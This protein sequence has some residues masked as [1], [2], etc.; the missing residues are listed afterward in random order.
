M[1]HRPGEGVGLSLNVYFR[2]YSSIGFITEFLEENFCSAKK[3]DE[4]R[5]IPLHLLLR[6]GN[7]F[8]K[9]DMKTLL[10]CLALAVSRKDM[11]GDL[12]LALE[13]KNKCK[14]TVI[15]ILLIHYPEA[16]KAL[17]VDVHHILYL[18]FNQGAEDRTILGLLNKAT[19]IST[20]VEKP[21]SLLPIHL[22]TQNEQSPFIVHNL[23]RRYMPIDIK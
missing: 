5:D 11:N 14:N 21:S 9:V 1:L 8:D 19:K 12:P 7:K 3:T 20:T 16:S 17:S 18:A 10:T 13:L 23:I 2:N 15:Y 22:A 6:C 4:N